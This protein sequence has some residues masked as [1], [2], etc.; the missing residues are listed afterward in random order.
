MRPLLSLFVLLLTLGMTAPALAQTASA[1]EA[2]V[3]WRLLDYVGVDYAGAVENGQ[4]TNPAEYGEM[5]EFS[6]QILTRLEALPSTSSKADLVR[7]AVALQ[8]AIR[9]KSD[10]R[11]VAGQAKTLAG[12][13]LAA[14]PSPLAPSFPPDLAK[15]A[16]LY[17]AQCA[18]C[19]GATGRAD[20]AGAQGLD[21]APIA[22][23]DVERARQRSVFGLYQVIDQ[24]LDG[25]AMA[26]NT[27]TGATVQ[28]TSIKVL[29]LV[30]DG[31]GFAFSL[32]LIR[33]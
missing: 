4:V 26:S 2:Q 9:N 5:V 33:Q 7:D 14:Y 19:H 21:P 3:A 11:T 10:P 29:W 17:D 28:T 24:G 31:V 1:S 20:G 13:V 15:G 30:R 8:D 25:T 12:A 22:F 16:A 23:A 6:S 18:V 27:R 32:N